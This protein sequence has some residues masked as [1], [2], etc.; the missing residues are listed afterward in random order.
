MFSVQCV[1]TRK[2]E[3][4]RLYSL[5]LRQA[6][7]LRRQARQLARLSQLIDVFQDLLHTRT[8][9]VRLR[10][11]GTLVAGGD[12]TSSLLSYANMLDLVPPAENIIFDK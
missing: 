4:A 1:K 6:V 10:A 11:Q 5:I 3:E 9:Q 2:G 8:V 12:A 7:V